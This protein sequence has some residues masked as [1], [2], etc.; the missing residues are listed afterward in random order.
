MKQ[1]RVS[2]KNHSMSLVCASVQL[3]RYAYASATLKES[4]QENLS[5]CK[6]E[7]FVA[8]ICCPNFEIEIPCIVQTSVQNIL[9]FYCP[10][11]QES[12]LISQ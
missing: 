8:C 12:R 5:F 7:K 11:V 1:K 2:D 6:N 9:V 10:I 4:K 3:K